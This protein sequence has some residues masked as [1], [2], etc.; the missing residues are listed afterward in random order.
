VPFISRSLDLESMAEQ[1]RPDAYPAKLG[2]MIKKQPEKM[3]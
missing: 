2:S 3:P 1:V